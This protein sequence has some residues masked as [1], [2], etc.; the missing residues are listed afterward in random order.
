MRRPHTLPPRP[1][2]SGEAISPLIP[3]KHVT[4]CSLQL[5]AALSTWPRCPCRGH[6][7]AHSELTLQQGRNLV[8]KVP[9]G[10]SSSFRIYQGLHVLW[11]WEVVAHMGLAS[12]PRQEEDTHLRPRR[13]LPA[14][15]PRDWETPP[16]PPALRVDFCP[17]LTKVSDSVH[18]CWT[19]DSNPGAQTQFLSS[20]RTHFDPHLS[21]FLTLSHQGKQPIGK[22][23][24]AMEDCAKKHRVSPTAIV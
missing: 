9:T 8:A 20:R 24:M 21:N 10:K 17:F 3:I 13:K 1:Q 7:S 2:N 16:Q 12:L 4:H 22:I 15:T 11:P 6:V 23:N 5:K 18:R 14:S 19:R